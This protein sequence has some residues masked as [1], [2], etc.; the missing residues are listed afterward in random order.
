LRFLPLCTRCTIISILY[1][2]CTIISI[3]YLFYCTIISILYIFYN[4][5]HP[6][7]LP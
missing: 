2:Y 7:P 5:L 6:A 3:L 1:L 4:V